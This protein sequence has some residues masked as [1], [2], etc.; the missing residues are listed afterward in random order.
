MG[1]TLSTMRKGRF[2]PSLKPNKNKMMQ[3]VFKIMLMGHQERLQKYL[4]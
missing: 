3:L 1:R 2:K 4:L